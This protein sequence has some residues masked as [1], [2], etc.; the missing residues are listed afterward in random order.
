MR[1][2][3]L[4]CGT[5]DRWYRAIC[6]FGPQTLPKHRDRLAVDVV[7]P[8]QLAHACRQAGG[9]VILWPLL[10]IPDPKDGKAA[11]S[12]LAGISHSEL[13]TLHL[14]EPP[15]ASAASSVPEQS[16]R[17]ASSPPIQ[18]CGMRVDLLQ[19]G[20][21]A[22]L[23]SHPQDLDR[24]TLLIRRFWRSIRSPEEPIESFYVPQSPAAD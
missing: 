6:R 10:E 2:Q 16:F 22:V 3:W 9:A 4:L 12:A 20:G 14:I 15:A 1:F 8:A 23:I 19:L 13:R 7:A 21:N 18:D 17:F 5:S 11:L 24:Y